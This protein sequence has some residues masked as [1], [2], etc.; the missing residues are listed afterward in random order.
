MGVDKSELIAAVK[1]DKQRAVEVVAA[2][3]ERA[4]RPILRPVAVDITGVPSGT[5]MFVY[6]RRQV[7]RELEVLQHNPFFARVDVS[8]TASRSQWRCC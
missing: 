3:R 2:A 8:S 7:Q 6:D 5:R 1:L 4:S